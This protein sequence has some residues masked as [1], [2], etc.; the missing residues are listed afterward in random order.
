MDTHVSMFGLKINNRFR[1][2][3]IVGSLYLSYSFV[4]TPFWLA[5]SVAKWTVVLAIPGFLVLSGF[6]WALWQMTRSYTFPA[7]FCTPT[8][9]LYPRYSEY[10]WSPGIHI[11]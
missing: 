3:M 10:L 7:G 5:H 1:R 6:A 9:G 8:A 2:R 11:L 4:V